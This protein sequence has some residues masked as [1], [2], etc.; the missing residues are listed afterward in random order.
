MKNFRGVSSSDI[1]L[2]KLAKP[3]KLTSAVKAIDLPQSLVVRNKIV[4]LTGWA[5][6]LKVVTPALSDRLQVVELPIVDYQTCRQVMDSLTGSSYVDSKTICTGPLTD[7]LSACSV[8][9]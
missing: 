1:A 5:S 9:N 4:T 7:S 2:L 6:T 3:L 8:S